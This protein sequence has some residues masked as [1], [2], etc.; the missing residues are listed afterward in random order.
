MLPSS[1]TYRDVLPAPHKRAFRIDVTDIDGNVRAADLRP[2][3]GDVQASLTQ[4]VTRSAT[5]SLGPEWYP[6][7]A[8]DPLSPEHAVVRIQAGVQY[9]DGSTELFPIFT[10]RVDTPTLNRDGVVEFQCYDLA[11]DVVAYPFEQP[12][13]TAVG[14]TLDEMRTLILEAVPQATFGTDDVTDTPTPVLTWNTDRGQALDDLAQSLGGRWYAL[15]N[16]D[17]VVRDFSYTLGP[18]Q[19]FYADGPRGTVTAADISR[20]RAGA[21]NSVIVVSERTDGT[22][23]IRVPARVQDPSN[24][25]YFGG[26]YGKVA[27]IIN[28]QTPLSVTQAQ[29]LARTQLSASTALREQWSV[30]LVPDMTLEPGDAIQFGYRGHTGIQIIDQLTYPLNHTEPMTIVGRAGVTPQ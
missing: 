14:M 17:F 9:G 15:G 8:D 7:V 20:S 19:A 29:D 26:K 24:P 2:F 3:S 30:E 25:L 1:T 4:R 13:T 16:G 28:V 21:F 22:D 10:G 5:F 27:Q 6:E 23:P 11:A 12:R 18:V